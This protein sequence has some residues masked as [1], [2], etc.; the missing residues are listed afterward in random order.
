MR[1][2][3][4]TSAQSIVTDPS[5]ENIYEKI[6]NRL[7]DED[8]TLSLIEYISIQYC[9]YLTETLTIPMSETTTIYNTFRKIAPGLNQ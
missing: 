9:H 1:R 5:S 4:I 8:L 3:I 2:G 7:D 6:K